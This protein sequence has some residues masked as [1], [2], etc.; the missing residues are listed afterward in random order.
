M[1]FTRHCFFQ[2]T[3]LSRT[4]LRLRVTLFRVSLFNAVFP[5]SAAQLPFEG[6]SFGAADGAASERTSG[7]SESYFRVTSAE[8]TMSYCRKKALLLLLLLFAVFCTLFTFRAPPTTTIAR[9]PSLLTRQLLLVALPLPMPLPLAATA[10]KKLVKSSEKRRRRRRT[11]CLQRRRRGGGGATVTAL[12]SE[13]RVG[14]APPSLAPHAVIA[15][16]LRC[17]AHGVQKHR[18]HACILGSKG[19]VGSEVHFWLNETECRESL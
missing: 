18:R 7:P 11:A 16:A 15:R 14:P 10:R 3:S 5:A 17:K 12:L 13:P 9:P 2:V 8:T 1:S 4:L 19:G 6:Q